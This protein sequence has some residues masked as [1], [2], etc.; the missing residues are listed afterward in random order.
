[1]FEGKYTAIIGNYKSSS[2][3]PAMKVLNTQTVKQERYEC[4]RYNVYVVMQ[5]AFALQVVLSSSVFG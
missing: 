2:C 1:M 5:A 3:V 4:E